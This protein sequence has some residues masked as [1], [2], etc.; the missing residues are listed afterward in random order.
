MADTG[1]FSGRAH[2][3]GA[4]LENTADSRSADFNTPLTYEAP[5]LETLTTIERKPSLPTILTIASTNVA[6]I[7]NTVFVLLN[8]R[9]LYL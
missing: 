4:S 5:A 7:V 3:T 8:S 9:K 2:K 6:L 1:W